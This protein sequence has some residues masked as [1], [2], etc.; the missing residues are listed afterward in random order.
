MEAERLPVD[1]RPPAGAGWPIETAAD[2]HYG[3]RLLTAL[4]RFGASLELLRWSAREEIRLADRAGLLALLE[5]RHQLVP[6]ALAS[7]I[8][9]QDPEALAFR[10]AGEPRLLRALE[11][12]ALR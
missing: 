10:L 9:A 5:T 3:E 1:P 4:E 6:Q 8:R 11:L 7:A 12:L 2:R